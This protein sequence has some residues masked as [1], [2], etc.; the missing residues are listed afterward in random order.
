MNLFIEMLKENGFERTGLPLSSPLVVHAVAGAGKT[1][2][3]RK[4]LASNPNSLAFT[5]GIP[6]RRN[7]ENRY[8]REFDSPVPGFFCILDEYPGGEY[9]E[10][11]DVLIADPLQHEN[12]PMSPHFIKATSHRFGKNT[13]DLLTGL[14]FN[15]IGLKESDRVN[16]S[17]IFGGPILGEVIALEPA[18][19]HLLLDHGL[20][21]HC[22]RSVLGQEFT[23]VT[24]VSF[25]PL[26]QFKD[27][28]DLYIALTR[29]SETLHVRTT[30]IPHPTP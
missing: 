9:K 13:E 17:H 19:R 4:Y 29:H 14:G 23:E 30:G 24:V 8:L 12:E 16:I 21:P 6:D 11:W 2:L 1:T 15:L 5:H 3:I 26:S 22:P 20:K 27:S 25:K 7:L 18:A 10:K 28:A